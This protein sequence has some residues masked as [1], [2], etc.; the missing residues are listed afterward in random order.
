ME[1]SKHSTF[2]PQPVDQSFMDNL[3]KHRVFLY[4][5]VQ[6]FL[7]CE[8][9]TNDQ[10]VHVYKN[11][12]KF[13][14]SALHLESLQNLHESPKSQKLSSKL[15]F[16]L[17]NK[18]IDKRSKD[19]IEKQSLA[20]QE[21]SDISS[22]MKSKVRYLAGACVQK[23]ASRLKASVIRKLGKQGKH[24]KAQRMWAYNK[25]RLLKTLTLTE[26][27]VM[28]STDDKDSLSEIEFKQGASR[29]LLHV[30]DSVFHFFLDLHTHVQ[31]HLGT[32]SLHVNLGNIHLYCR[33][34]IMAE[35]SLF[36]SWIDL[37]SEQ[38]EQKEQDDEDEIFLSMLFELFQLV[39]EHF[40]RISIAERIQALKESIPKKKKQALR[41]KI[42][43][44]TTRTK[45]AQKN[46]KTF[47]ESTKSNKKRK[48]S[49][50]E[51]NR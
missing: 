37:F 8:P 42:Q 32:D 40:L 50:E 2:C 10:F 48:K 12:N 21:I 6:N 36:Q 1:E 7:E 16:W 22:S 39:S 24:S 23:I 17:L 20:G 15:L 9:K 44:L 25:Q 29:G 4:S 18:E 5:K 19:L 3:K 51:Q 30:S 47:T 31:K 33:E 14:G 35:E 43:A 45:T 28:N 11:V 34:R 49:T 13:L 41:T 27:Q 46:K 38:D 26:E